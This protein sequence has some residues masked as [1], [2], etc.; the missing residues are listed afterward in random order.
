MKR[1]NFLHYNSIFYTLLFILGSQGMAVSASTLRDIYNDALKNDT[2]YYATVTQNKA[3]EVDKSLALSNVLPDISINANANEFDS[4]T[5]YKSPGFTNSN[6]SYRNDTYGVTLRQTIYNHDYFTQLSQANESVAIAQANLITAKQDLIVRVSAAYFDVLFAIDSLDFAQ[7]EKKA[8]G[9]QLHQ[10]KQ[11]FEVGL[12]AITDVHESQ[13]LYDQSI[14]DEIIAMN[15]LDINKEKLREITGHF[16]PQFAALKKETPLPP[17]DPADVSEWVKAALQQNTALIAAEK[18]MNKAKQE[19]SRAQS[20]HYPTLDLVASKTTTDNNA[21][22]F[23]SD[24]DSTV[25]TLNLALPIYQGGRTSS[26]SRQASYLYDQ[27]RQLYLQTRRKTERETRSSYL[28]VIADISTVKALKQVRISKK[29]ALEATQAG[30]EVGTRTAVEVLTSQ[31]DLFRARRDY[32]N[33]RYVFINETLK[34]RRAAGSLT[35]SAIDK[36]TMWLE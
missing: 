20:G 5:T 6:Q 23:G 30:F 1:S 29:I 22:V 13:A 10:T 25:I 11:R 34:L 2:T 35:E 24:T 27:N 12:T 33:A 17:P 18:S 7:L 8:I 28:T 4:E 19:I 21:P 14:A 31:R 36:I 16:Y 26:R 32:A 9:Q 3:L 15:T